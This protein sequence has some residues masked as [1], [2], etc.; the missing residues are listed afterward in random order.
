MNLINLF[1][2]FL[3]IGAVS[4]G[5]GYAMILGGSRQIGTIIPEVVIEE[6]HRDRLIITDHPVESGAAISDHAF[7]MPVEV[8]MRVGWSDSAWNACRTMVVRSTSLNVPICGSPE[9]P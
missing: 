3:K 4:F 6:M 2:V 5:G 9:G 7:K 1:L 8:D